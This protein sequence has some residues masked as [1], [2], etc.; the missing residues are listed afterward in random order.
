VIQA[1]CDEWAK[2]EPLKAKAF[3]VDRVWDAIVAVN[4]EADF[5][6]IK[7]PG[8]F[9]TW[10][11]FYDDINPH[12]DAWKVERGFKKTITALKEH[13]KYVAQKAQRLAVC[14]LLFA[15]SLFTLIFPF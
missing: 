9:K 2:M 15:G 12:T 3:F 10:I 11:E 1:R 5:D 7:P 14:S 4:A 13:D 8:G 6:A